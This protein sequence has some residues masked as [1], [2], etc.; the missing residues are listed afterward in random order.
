LGC[1][2]STDADTLVVG[3]GPNGLVAAIRL[4]EAGQRVVNRDVLHPS[5]AQ[6]VDAVI[7]GDRQDPRFERAA[8]VVAAQIEISPQERLLSGILGFD[9]IGQHAVAQVIDGI[10]IGIEQVGEGVLVARDRRLYPFKDDRILWHRS[11]RV[12]S[13]HTALNSTS[14]PGEHKL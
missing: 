14:V 6:P 7:R 11:W 5:P 8:G 1:V 9:V 2:L 12:L 3:S 10:L 4:A 13:V